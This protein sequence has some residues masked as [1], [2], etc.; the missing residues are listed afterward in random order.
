MDFFFVFL[1]LYFF[2]LLVIE[3]QLILLTVGKTFSFFSLFYFSFI[4]FYTL[5]LLLCFLL[6]L[7][8]FFRPLFSLSSFLKI[9]FK[10]MFLLKKR[11]LQNPIRILYWGRIKIGFICF[12]FSCFCI[13]FIFL[14]SWIIKPLMNPANYLLNHHHHLP[15]L[16]LINYSMKSISNWIWNGV[17]EVGTHSL[18]HVLIRSQVLLLQVLHCFPEVLGL[19][20]KSK[21]F[22]ACLE[23][24]LQ[25]KVIWAIGSSYK[26]FVNLL[27]NKKSRLQILVQYFK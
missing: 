24:M 3:G 23:A 20:S 2:F 22:V 27:N 1:I 17:Q 18:A 7:L 13:Y 10:T 16:Y 11:G 6:P 9:H 19:H 5:L 26:L 12:C 15:R 14:F 8:F 21:N 25:S 4:F